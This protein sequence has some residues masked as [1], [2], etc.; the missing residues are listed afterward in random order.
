M[1]VSP[2]PR[3]GS[4]EPAGAAS[5]STLPGALDAAPQQP[6][7]GA[8]ERAFTTLSGEPIGECYTA[9]DM[10]LGAGLGGEDDP[11]GAPGEYPFTRGIHRTMY[12]GRLWT[13]RQFAGFGTS[14]ETNERF[15]YLLEHGQTGLSTAFDMPSLMGHDSDHARSL[16]EVG[17]EGVAVDTLED[18]QTL[19]SGVDLGEVSVS[20]TINAPA[21]IMLAFFVAAAES[22]GAP[23]G[24]AHER[25]P[26]ER[27]SGTIQADILKEYI[28]QKE[29]CF[30]IDPAMRLC[31]D[32]IEWCTRRMPRWHP[33]SIS[34]YHIREAGATAQQELA[35]TLKD[36]LTYVEQAVARG[37]DVDE[38]A[39]RLSFFFN[40]QI[41]FFEEVAK[42]R[43]ARRIWAREMR[44]RFGAK[45]PRS[46][47]MRFH[48][49]TAGVSLTAQQPLNNIVRTAV[50][51]LAA[52]LGGTQSLHT[53]SYDE[54][55]ALPT[56][57]AVRIALRTQQIIAEETGVASTIDPLGGAYFVEALT[58][59]LQ[60]RAYEYF[61]KIDELG[62]MVEAVKR[63][64]PQREIADAAFEL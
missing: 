5:A 40:A 29:W 46:W 12:R 41:D 44:E 20:M 30:P 39:P 47:Q 17:R 43:A 11:I 32:M 31:G 22:D 3:A 56:E 15:H 59:R 21:A 58:D 51:A 37:L 61:R 27:L 64:F 13:M 62:G 53:N 34:G 6:R 55:L 26:A 50:E 60:E 19:F 7:A 24:A 8:H 52:V 57:Q 38:F 45:D 36:G 23:G 1:A 42:Y 49:Q 14:E 35:F 9:A 10:P 33:I 54:A 28:A 18:M 48:A 2:K 25:V 16:G 63:G 4:G